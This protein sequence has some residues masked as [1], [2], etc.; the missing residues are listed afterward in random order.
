MSLLSGWQ[1]RKLHKIRGSTA[2]EVTDYQIRIVV[3]YGSGTDNGEHVYLDGKCRSDFGDIRFTADDGVT[4][5]PYWI[6][7]KV[8]GNYAVF[9]V[10]IPYI[11]AYPDT[12]TIYIYYGNQMLLQQVMVKIHLNSLMILKVLN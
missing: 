2:G 6:E 3:H 7:E 12:T 11:P 8:D 10:K 5:L 1:Y 4:E 9:W